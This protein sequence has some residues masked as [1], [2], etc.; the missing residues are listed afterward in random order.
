M[1]AFLNN[2]SKA[3]RDA[4]VRT[5]GGLTTSQAAKERYN[6]GTT[7]PRT[8][9]PM[10]SIRP[11]SGQKTPSPPTKPKPPPKPITKVLPT[12][13]TNMP[14]ENFHPF[15]GATALGQATAAYNVA[16]QTLY[17]LPGAHAQ[18][19]ETPNS[20]RPMLTGSPQLNRTEARLTDSRLANPAKSPRHS[21]DSI[22]SGE[23]PP[24]MNRWSNGPDGSPKGFKTF[25]RTP[26]QVKKTPSSPVTFL[27]SGRNSPVVD[28][29]D[30]V[31]R[32]HALRRGI[33]TSPILNRPGS[34]PATQQIM[35]EL[36][37][38]IEGLSLTDYNHGQLTN[39][40]NTYRNLSKRT[41]QAILAAPV[42]VVVQ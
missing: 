35:T 33:Q 19:E 14:M 12:N 13:V 42:E 11:I 6:T 15:Q 26:P 36:S 17:L 18:T 30:L 37:T 41:Q 1:A 34:L 32:L 28:Q 16:N 7:L 10:H 4:Y 21:P 38:L 27:R 2:M 22:A 25:R 23:L 40:V 8:Q 24:R 3:S 5:I 29:T 9:T 20:P 39:A 31:S